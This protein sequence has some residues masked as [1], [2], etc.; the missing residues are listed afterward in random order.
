MGS[1]QEGLPD[2]LVKYT[3][4]LEGL[5]AFTM[6]LLEILLIMAAFA[7]AAR[8]TNNVFLEVASII[9]MIP[10]VMFSAV[11]S[12]H[13]FLWNPQPRK[14]WHLALVLVAYLT[15]S[16]GFPFAALQTVNGIVATQIEGNE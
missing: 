14:G 8:I 12:R 9:S 1:K 11:H 16:L 10:L 15:I 2:G 7:T 13:I 3:K 4:F 6:T 5:L